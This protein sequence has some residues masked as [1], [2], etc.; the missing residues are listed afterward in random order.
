MNASAKCR[1]CP[2]PAMLRTSQGAFLCSACWEALEFR[3]KTIDPVTSVI[4]ISDVNA[5]VADLAPS[6]TAAANSV[7][8]GV[9]APSRGTEA[10]LSATLA[11]APSGSLFT[12]KGDCPGTDE[13]AFSDRLE[14]LD[15]ESVSSGTPGACS[16]E[17]EDVGAP[18][19]ESRACE[20]NGS[21]AD[22]SKTSDGSARCS[23]GD[24]LGNQQPGSNTWGGRNA[25]PAPS[26][27]ARDRAI[28]PAVTGFD[29][30]P[31][32]SPSPLASDTD[33]ALVASSFSSP[34]TGNT[35]SSDVQGEIVAGRALLDFEA[36][37]AALELHWWTIGIVLASGVPDCALLRSQ[38]SS[39][40]RVRAASEITDN[41]TSF[42]EA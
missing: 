8:G 17:R 10:Q 40:S 25:T 36:E 30:N 14:I 24:G 29:S 15:L 9:P 31:D 13:P 35:R 37:V 42:S 4:P 7:S 16:S 5:A 20:G 1:W 3:I 32:A 18:N 21:N 23:S 41:S 19:S 11:F 27:R 28:C 38:Y 39:T 2:A 34:A 6:A 26:G 12:A 22:G 33:G